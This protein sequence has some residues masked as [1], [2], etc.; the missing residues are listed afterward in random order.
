MKTR[1]V[2]TFTLGATLIV[3]GLL[4]MLHIFTITISYA[5]IMKLWPIVFIFL[6]IEVLFSYFQDKEGRLT[7]D[8]GAIF[9]MI[10]LTFFT[11]GMACVEWCFQY[12]QNYVIL[13]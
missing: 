4:F 11:I 5:F 12:A 8:G 9:I 13:R 2:G 10:L 7:Y 1:K 3:F 6:G